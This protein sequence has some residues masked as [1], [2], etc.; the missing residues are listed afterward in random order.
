MVHSNLVYFR[1]QPM[2]TVYA[3][4]LMNVQLLYL[5]R[6]RQGRMTRCYF[7]LPISLASKIVLVQQGL[8]LI[9]KCYYLQM[10]PFLYFK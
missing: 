3:F 1:R 7:N 4:S 9:N 10:M 5:A 6:N 2:L 8:G